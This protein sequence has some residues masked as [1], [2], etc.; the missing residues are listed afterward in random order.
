MNKK[1]NYIKEAS[2]FGSLRQVNHQPMQSNEQ[3][4][5][6]TRA[7]R[8]LTLTVEGLFLSP[9]LFIFFAAFSSLS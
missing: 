8:R 5:Q 7:A 4:S 9:K 3:I 1:Y 2:P 6:P